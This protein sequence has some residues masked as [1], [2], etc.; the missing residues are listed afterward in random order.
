MLKAFSGKCE[1]CGDSERNRGTRTTMRMDHCHITGV[2]RGW[3]C[4]QCNILI[5]M[6]KEDADRLETAARW[7]R[8]SEIKTDVFVLTG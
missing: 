7:L 2:F 5:G 3:L 6:A 4:H 1:I 8:E